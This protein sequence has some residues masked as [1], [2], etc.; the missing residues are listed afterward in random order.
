MKVE[1]MNSVSQV[2]EITAKPNI[3]GV[4]EAQAKAEKLVETISSAKSLVSELV[5]LCRNLKVTATVD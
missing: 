3:E 4:D 1:K 2:V 5:E